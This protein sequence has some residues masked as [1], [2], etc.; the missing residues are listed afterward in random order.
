[1]QTVIPLKIASSREVARGFNSDYI[2]EKVK[3]AD[4]EKRAMNEYSS[5]KNEDG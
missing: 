3:M 4:K 2:F 5:S 1:L